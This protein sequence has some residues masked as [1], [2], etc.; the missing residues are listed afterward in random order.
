[1]HYKVRTEEIWVN[2]YCVEADSEV[3]ARSKVLNGTLGT[4]YVTTDGSKKA[5]PKTFVD[6]LTVDVVE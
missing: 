4:D 6:F 2:Y 5:L 3:E 1:M